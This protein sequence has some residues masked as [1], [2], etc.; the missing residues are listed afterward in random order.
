MIRRS[1]PILARRAAQA[2]GAVLVLA[3]L[4]ALANP[5]FA[6]QT[7][8]D[9]VDCHIKGREREGKASLNP[10][11]V[12]FMNCGFKFC[13]TQQAAPPVPYPPAP[14][15][16]PPAPGPMPMPAPGP[17]Y[18]PGPAPGPAPSY[19]PGPAPGPGQLNGMF[20]PATFRD[21]CRNGDSY[22]YVRTGLT[23]PSTIAFVLKNN[24]HVTL[25]LPTSATFASRCGEFPS[26]NAAQSFVKF[27]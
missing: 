23:H 1:T 24:H 3:P 10:L 5:F 20:R 18:S 11:G 2:L 25:M 17:P 22:F 8:R 12:T 21:F 6:E 27:D 9:C 19:N 14:G 15:P 7:G 26:A 16:Y 4:S 13:A